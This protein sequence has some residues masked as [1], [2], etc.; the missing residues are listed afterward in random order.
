MTARGGERTFPGMASDLLT[1]PAADM[2]RYRAT[3]LTREAA[4]QDA[5][6]ARRARALAVA[7]QAADMLRAEFGATEVVLFGSLARAGPVSWHTDVDLAATGVPP[8]CFFA[9]VGRLQALDPAVA[10]DLVRIEE[11]P[12]SLLAVIREEGVLP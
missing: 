10:V 1:I 4:R 7:R 3:A 9:A 11:A 2:A 6:A 5:L 8:E 12:A